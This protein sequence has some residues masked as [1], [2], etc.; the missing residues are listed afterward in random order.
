MSSY[1]ELKAYINGYWDNLR[2]I[3]TMESR[4]HLGLPHPYYVSSSEST[5]RFSFPYM[6][7]WDSYFIAQGLFG[8][9]RQA[10][11]LELA[12]NMFDL[13]ERFGFMPS[14]NSFAH[15]SRSQ[16]PMLSRLVMQLVNAD[17]QKLDN[18]WLE[19]AYRAIKTELETCWYGVEH[20]H[21]RKVHSGL[22]RYLSLIHI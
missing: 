4:L 12:N 9:N 5:D 19:R 18:K 20:P 14:S 16:P 10:H 8:T 15:L 6:F 17:D 3:N 7:Y 21:N 1:T 13:I 11:V 22:S 2:V